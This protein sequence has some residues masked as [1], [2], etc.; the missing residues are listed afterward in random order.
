MNAEQCNGL[1]I[2]QTL[3][4]NIS[5]QTNTHIRTHVMI[6]SHF[7]IAP[8]MHRFTTGS[9]NKKMKCQFWTDLFA[10]FK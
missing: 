6:L 3:R 1:I 4:K 7:S 2:V 9:I 10:F 5:N 8:T